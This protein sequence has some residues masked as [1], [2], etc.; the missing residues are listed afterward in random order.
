[1]VNKMVLSLGTLG[2]CKPHGVGVPV[3]SRSRHDLVNKMVLSL[4]TL[5]GC[6]PHLRYY[7]NNGA[8]SHLRV[9]GFR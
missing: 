9:I 5:G 6:K 3:A 2:G 7:A 1:M 4:G 8:T